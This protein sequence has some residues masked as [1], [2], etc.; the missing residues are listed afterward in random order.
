[1]KKVLCSH[2]MNT[3][4][5]VCKDPDGTGGRFYVP[6]VAGRNLL[7]DARIV[8]AFPSTFIPVEAAPVAEDE[9]IK[10][11]PDDASDESLDEVVSDLVADVDVKEDAE[12]EG[13]PFVPVGVENIE[14]ISDV[15]AANAKETADE[16]DAEILAAVIEEANNEE[17]PMSLNDT[18]DSFTSKKKLDDYGAELGVKLDG[19]KKLADMKLAL[20]EA[21]KEE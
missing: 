7:V 11:N 5:F 17:A 10:D 16:V 15:E 21:L 19:R 1:M 18:I 13:E 12:N 8:E 2:S 20:K 6:V 14:D 4:N 9:E 3:T